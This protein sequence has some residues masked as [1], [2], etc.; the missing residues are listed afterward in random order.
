MAIIF[1][2]VVLVVSDHTIGGVYR[3][4][5]LM[6]DSIGNTNSKRFHPFGLVFVPFLFQAIMVKV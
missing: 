2:Q 6:A 5:K 1:C 4:S 3:I